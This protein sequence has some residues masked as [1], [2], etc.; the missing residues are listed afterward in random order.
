[1]PADYTTMGDDVFRAQF[2]LIV[3]ATANRA[4]G[5]EVA[6]EPYMRRDVHFQYAVGR[7]LIR[8][9]VYNSQIR[10]EN[11][12]MQVRDLIEQL[13]PGVEV[14]DS[15]DRMAQI[16]VLTSGELEVPAALD[17]LDPELGVG[18]VTPD[19]L[20]SI[21]PGSVTN[22]PASEPDPIPGHEPY[23]P[24]VA[25]T[26]GAGVKIYIPDRGLA[27]KPPNATHTWLA[28]AA[29]ELG[30]SAVVSGELDPNVE[31]GPPAVL[32]EYAAHGTFCA[33]VAR[34][35]A[36]ATTL[37]VTD[38]FRFAGAD[39][40]SFVFANLTAALDDG[41][42]IISLSAGG[43]TRAD[44]PLLT[45]QVFAERLQEE[46]NR[47]TILIAAAGNGYTTRPFHPAA[48]ESVYGVGALAFDQLSRA[49]FSNYG[50]WVNIWTL[51]DG[52]INAFAEGRY[53]YTEPPRKGSSV[54]F[55][56]MARWSGTSFSTPLFAGLVAGRMS[57]MA[58][59]GTPET[60]REAA[61]ALISLAAGKPPVPGAGPFLTFDQ[62]P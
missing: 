15:P 23:P 50:D 46:D 17:L 3:A 4:D 55:T 37:T 16:T 52:M 53:T 1:M 41:P 40:E 22:C 59:A 11:Q 33:G 49:W 57:R 56:G 18:T 47:G 14:L 45:A 8:T 62:A 28:P 38:A 48:D 9:D 21:T 35:A 2:G 19:H 12:D 31:V 26:A 5:I 36:P 61:D 6:A 25:G 54:T 20:L 42:H 29:S 58:A 32:R 34:C 24:Q 39:L 51:G 27:E 60:S 30:P 43:H 10:Y 44:Q 13:I 7:M